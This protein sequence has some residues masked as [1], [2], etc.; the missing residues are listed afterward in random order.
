MSGTLSFISDRPNICKTCKYID[1]K[2]A[3]NMYCFDTSWFSM[4]I[5]DWSVENMTPNVIT[6]RMSLHVSVSIIR[7]CAGWLQMMSL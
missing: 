2:T 3:N 5:V 4:L 7:L 1:L 6:Y